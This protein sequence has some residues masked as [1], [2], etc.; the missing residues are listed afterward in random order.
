VKLSSRQ[1]SEQVIREVLSHFSPTQPDLLPALDELNGRLGYLSSAAIES[2]AQHFHLPASQVHGAASFYAMWHVGAPPE[3]AVCLCE[4]GPCHAAGAAGT[5]RALEKAGIE[6]KRTSCI[7]HC[8]RGPVAV[9]GDQLY[10]DV[11]P[12]RVHA[13]LAGEEP[14]P[15]SPADEIIGIEVDDRAHAL[16]RNVGQIDPRSLEDALEAG[17]YGALRK[18]LTEMEPEQVVEEI[19]TS[20]LQGRGGAG[21]PTGLKMRFTAAGAKSA[22]GATYV[23]CNADE[24]EPGTFKDRILIEGDPHQLLEGIA[25]AGYAIGAHEGYIYIRGEYADQAALLK[26]AIR[27]AE[28]AGTLG[29]N[30]MDSGFDFHIHVH[31][32]AGAYICGEETALLEGLEGKRGEPRVRPPYPTTCGLFGQATLINNVE[33]LSNLPGIIAHGA[34]WYRQMGTEK[35]PGTKLYPISGHVKRQGCLEAPLG[36]FT[37]A[38]LIEG[39][40][41]GMR[42]DAPFKACH[43]GGAAGEI[44]GPEFL[45][46]SLEFGACTTAG[47]MLGAGDVLV[48]DADTCIVDYVLSVANFFRAE[49]CGKCTPCRVGTERYRQ[50][51]ADLVSGQGTS[52]QLDELTYWG[53]L[54]VDS[55]FCGLGQTAPT[56]VMSA[57]QLFR[58]EFEAHARGECPAGVCRL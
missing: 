45:D 17:A 58:D 13:I 25:I 15:L 57:L 52:E 26:Q 18:A 56:A 1:S 29:Q 39:P 9:A 55:S 46:I 53:E 28:A 23:V 8:A 30:M 48:L 11:T 35:S 16:L 7:G 6:V 14:T 3:E 33:T 36:A 31:S 40:A 4:D 43:L 27:D 49:S 51:L 10:R 21:F 12:A 54:M 2:A 32:G 42:G 19:A 20:G 44:V 34:D 50:I 5:R 24:S 22:A 38:Q 41:S 47:A 37:L